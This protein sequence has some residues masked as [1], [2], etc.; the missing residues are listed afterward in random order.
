MAEVVRRNALKDVLEGIGSVLSRSA[1]ELIQ[2]FDALE[3]LTCLKTIAALAF[4]YSIFTFAFGARWV[5][6]LGSSTHIAGPAASGGGA[7][8]R[9]LVDSSFVA[10]MTGLVN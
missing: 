6:L 9:V 1:R 2:A 8:L 3:Q 7:G 10:E 4:L 5:V